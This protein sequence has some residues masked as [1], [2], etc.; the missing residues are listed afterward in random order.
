MIVSTLYEPCGETEEMHSQEEHHR[1]ENLN[2]TCTAEEDNIP[3]EVPTKERVKWPPMNDDN[4]WKAFEETTDKVLETTLAGSIGRKAESQ[5]TIIHTIGRETFGIETKVKAQRI[6]S[7][8]RRE[9]EIRSIRRELKAVKNQW[10]KCDDHEKEGIEAI[11]YDLRQRLQTLRRAER[12]RQ[13]RRRRVKARSQFIKSPFNYVKKLLGNP[14]GGTLES[15]M[16]DVEQYLSD[17]HTD[18]D[19]NTELDECRALISPTEPDAPFKMSEIQID[20]VREVVKKA[21]SRSAPGYSGTSY[22]VYKK[23]PKLLK[24]P[25]EAYQR[26]VEEGNHP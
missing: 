24:T 19:S 2:E 6:A 13:K 7:V 21:R 3:K 20:E 4:A 14:K 10:K 25:L 15:G 18:N 9:T 23:Y 12:N 17:T 26:G 8:S 5:S 11:R 1:A 16:K 22:K